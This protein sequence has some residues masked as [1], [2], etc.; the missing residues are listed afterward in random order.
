MGKLWHSNKEAKKHAVLSAKE[1]KQ[2]KHAKKEV[3]VA[4]QWNNRDLPATTKPH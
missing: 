4:V 3:H 1:K 2:A